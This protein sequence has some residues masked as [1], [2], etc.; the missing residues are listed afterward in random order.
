MISIIAILTKNNVIKEKKNIHW[1][2]PENIKWFKKKTINKNIIMGR[3]TWEFFKK[4]FKNRVN[5]IISN[6]IKN[7]N[8]YK[9]KKTKVIFANSIIKALN[10][11]KKNKKKIFIIGG[12]KIYLQTI[13]WSK[14]MYLIYINKKIYGNKFFPK[15]NKKE[16]KIIYR[17]IIYIKN[18]NIKYITFNIF[19]KKICIKR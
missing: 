7:F 5:F 3:K 8:I 18:F 15:Y 10:I 2:I 4:P 6:K 12:E 9:Y 13:K 11:A 17:K 14:K 16:W 1:K 19:K